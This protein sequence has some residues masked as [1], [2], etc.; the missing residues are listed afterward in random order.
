V[1]ENARRSTGPRTA[2][3]KAVSAR[4][5]TRHGCYAGPE[6]I[7]AGPFREEADEVRQF[8]AEV[9][10]GL[11]PRD[12]LE[13][14]AAE[15]IARV[16]LQA[17]RLAALDDV[18]LTGAA[19]LDVVS[20]ADRRRRRDREA[21][22]RQLRDWLRDALRRRDDASGRQAPGANDTAAEAT[23]AVPPPRHRDVLGLLAGADAGAV[24]DGSDRTP[25]SAAGPDQD[26]DEP[27][28]ALLTG[29][30]GDLERAASWAEQQHDELLA[31]TADADADA[32]ARHDVAE[33]CLAVLE[34][35]TKLGSR[36][37]LELDRARH[38]RTILLTRPLSPSAPT[39]PALLALPSG[40]AA[41]TPGTDADGETNPT[42]PPGTESDPAAG[43]HGETKAPAETTTP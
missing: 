22:L 20:A 14:A 32:R 4:N 2:E 24:L 3:G 37:G 5:S 13:L 1:L 26:P 12:R 29:R 35:T 36:L 42:P 9:V 11:A 40:A 27:L 38:A 6:P 28:T 15:R 30:F 23:A 19:A 41:D 31:D 7:A 10:D 8:Y 33:R 34:R 18:L 17:R 25:T 43:E 16:H 21:M 39:R